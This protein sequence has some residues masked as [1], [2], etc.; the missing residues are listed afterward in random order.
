MGVTG[1]TFD[2]TFQGPVGT[3]TN[4]WQS[5]GKFEAT[6][7]AMV[8]LYQQDVGGVTVTAQQTPKYKLI[9]NL[10]LFLMATGCL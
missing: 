1:V 6:D 5:I 10:D 3:Y 9:D 7:K 8:D 4:G 2:G